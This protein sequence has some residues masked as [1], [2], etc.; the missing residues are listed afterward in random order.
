MFPCFNIQPLL[1]GSFLADRCSDVIIGVCYQNVCTEHKI[2]K[3]LEVRSS[4]W[5]QA[6]YTFEILWRE[7]SISIIAA[8][9]KVS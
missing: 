5:R 9:D 1:R 6:V 3:K 4:D 8:F 7:S 2:A